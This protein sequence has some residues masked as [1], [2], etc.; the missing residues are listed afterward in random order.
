MIQGKRHRSRIGPHEKKEALRTPCAS[1]K[2]ALELQG[3]RGKDTT[4]RR[5]TPVTL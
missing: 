4:D 1:R 3:A 5:R 2:N